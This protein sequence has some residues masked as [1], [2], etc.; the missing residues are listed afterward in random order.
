MKFKTTLIII[1]LFL[2][3]DCY[4]FSQS[5]DEKRIK[6]ADK[7]YEM[8]EY[9]RAA[10]AYNSLQRKI[11]NKK[12]KNEV[13]FKMGEAYYQ[14][15]DYKKAKTN[16]RKCVKDR[17]LEYFASLRIGEID[18]IEGN[19]EEAL[20][21]YTDL[22]E[23]YPNDSVAKDGYNTANAVVAW[24]SEKI[25]YKVEP[26][27]QLNSRDDDFCPFVDEKDGYDHIYFTSVRKEAKGKKS[28]IT[29]EK[30]A[31]IF[32]T[33][34]DKKNKWS[35]P[36]SLDSIN[37][38]FDDGTPLIGNN[39]KNF[40]FT[41]CV[42]EKGKEMGCQIYEASKIEGVWM[43]AQRLEIT[44]DSLSIGHPAM[45]HDGSTIYF[46]ARLDGGFGGADIWYSQKEGENWSKPKNMGQNINS[47]GD[48]L[49]PFMREDG[50]LYYSSDK[51]P[52]MGGLDIFKATKDDN[53]KWTSEN[54][55]TPFNSHGN[56][57]GIYY[58]AKQEK[59]Y[60][61]SDRKGSKGNDIYYFELIPIE[62]N[63]TGSVKDKDNNHIIDSALVVLYGSDGSTF[64]DTI[65]L[66]NKKANYNFKLKHNTDYV[67]VVTK[68]GYFNGKSRFSTSN[69]EYSHSFQYDILLES[70]NKTFEIP[71]IEFEFGRWDLTEPSKYVL[72]S[73]V[74]IMN[75]NPY[76]VIEMSA[77]T[78]MIGSDEANLEL[79]QRRAN[80]VVNYFKTKGIPNGRLIAV[81]YGE[82][83]P[84]V[85]STP[86]IKYPFLPKGTVL[87]ES[88]INTL[89]PE[90]QIVANQ[91]NRRI[92]M[93]VMSNDYMPDLDW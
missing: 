64:R 25:K 21:V 56:D 61:S 17:E 77:H 55:K 13:Y 18:I 91:Q 14:I 37:T 4:V 46:S 67:F 1:F 54:M 86:N 89:E 80:S 41:R 22:L 82:S 33:K 40:Y 9:Y 62:F 78:D 3:S 5:K 58:Y 10:Q 73:I 83:K 69:L 29:G 70:F 6:R 93:K 27:K 23:K 79:S 52:S 36:E 72:D 75:D 32:V 20:K 31:D 45:S 26:A 38:I 39:G 7:I 57:Y 60:F 68:S 47:K 71:N 2:I 92:E 59:G 34:F 49:F 65:L 50:T 88:F 15:F 66:A 81:G 85:I 44:G 84:K 8:G 53:G 35:T 11:K 87:S 12:L 19:F 24:E 63:L 76:I 42:I 90:Q 16:Y 43:N 30:L 51:P 48:E 74:K 28:K